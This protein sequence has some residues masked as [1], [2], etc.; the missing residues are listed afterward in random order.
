MKKIVGIAKNTSY[1][2]LALIMQKIIS[3]TYFT[4]LARNLGPDDLGKYYFAISFTTLFAIFIDLGLNNVLTRE[5]AKTKERAEEILGNIL[6]FKIPLSVI[7]LAAVVAVI[8]FLGYTETVKTLVYLSSVSMILDSF[9]A[10][11]Y[12]VS[13]GFH[14]LKYES[15]GSVVYMIIAIFFGVIALK[16]GLSLNWIMTALVAAAF[17]N[18]LF[19]LFWLIKKWKIK[20]IPVYNKK[21]FSF[22]F[23]LSIPF[24]LY[25][26][27]QR[28]YMYLDTV[29]LSIMAG[30]TYVGLYQVAFKV[31]F[32]LQFLP[33][34]FT[35]SLY[36]AM[37]DYYVNNKNQLS[38]T[39]E[40]AMNYLIIISVPI[41]FGIMFLAD[42]IILIFKSGYNDAILP[43][44]IIIASLLFVFINFPIGSLL[45][46]C[47][48]QKIN[49]INM[50]IVTITSIILNLILISKFKT[51][52]ASI[53]VLITNIL[54]FILGIYHVSKTIAY[55]QK[56][57]ILTFL[58]VL[59]SS[60][61]MALAVF[62]LK[63][64]LNVFLVVL[65]GGIIYFFALL[66][67]K[68]VK[69]EDFLSI[70]NS[71]LKK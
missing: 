43:L 44:Q 29:L 66:S 25:A 14:N 26:V 69:R 60:L 20:I 47:D 55:R 4:I 27:F 23:K 12:S 13:R 59:L 7:T 62:Y 48:K 9:T 40:R 54:M 68:G 6:S 58:K 45:N 2:T 10:S 61:I 21:L 16:M 1:L 53:T 34:A 57:V 24:G 67:F 37:S 35:A 15:I 51:I 52:G 64:Y 3:F 5:I 36:P 46:A 70:Y 71:F 30:D 39:F 42:K 32:A 50:I 18:F 31:V 38:I 11:F 63:N 8:N 56:K 17:F 49:T 22:I 19:S 65:I 28:F 33:M 41:S